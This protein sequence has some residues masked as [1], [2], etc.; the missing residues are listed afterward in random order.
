MSTP[1]FLK[2]RIIPKRAAREVSVNGFFWSMTGRL[3]PYVRVNLFIFC[4]LAIQVIVATAFDGLAHNIPFWSQLFWSSVVLTATFFGLSWIF[5]RFIDHRDF[6]TLGL[7][8]QPGS[9]KQLGM[10]LAIGTRSD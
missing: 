8:L 5:V 1:S 7:T 4:V 10:G 3:R 2:I 9:A 6:S